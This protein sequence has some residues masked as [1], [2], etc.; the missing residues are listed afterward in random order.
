MSRTNILSLMFDKCTIS[1]SITDSMWRF[2]I[3]IDKDY[4]CPRLWEPVEATLVENNKK[5]CVFI[6]FPISKQKVVRDGDEYTRLSGVSYGWYVANRPL[7]PSERTLQSTQSGSNIIIE[8]PITYL[9]RLFFT[10]GNRLGLHKGYWDGSTTGWGSNELPYHQFESNENTTIQNVLDDICAY[11]GL[12]HMDYW[13]STG[14]DWNPVSYLVNSANLDT[15]MNLPAPL[16][17]N[18]SDE[19]IDARTHQMIEEIQST[20][21]G[22]KWKNRVYVDAKIQDT[23][24]WYTAVKPATWDIN[25]NGLERI[26]QYCEELPPGTDAQ[27]W[28]TKRCN[29]IYSLLCTPTT[30]FE[31]PF[32]YKFDLQ[33]FQKIQFKGFSQIP[34][35]MMRITELSYDFD[36]DGGATCSARCTLDRDWAAARA[37]ALILKQDSLSLADAIRKIVNKTTTTNHAGTVTGFSGGSAIV[38]YGNNVETKLGYAR[39]LN[40]G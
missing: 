12:I 14:T 39:A 37:L 24:N 27:S 8:D 28:A 20:E 33:L 19:Q 3:E 26:Y 5:Y 21:E 22:D 4:P 15:K 40:N 7:R 9:N 13:K 17:L 2:D 10:G 31:V 23:D 16:I 38:S 36:P 11:T 32:W 35:D 1:R 29:Q 18:A 6:G 34:Q 25:S 30:T